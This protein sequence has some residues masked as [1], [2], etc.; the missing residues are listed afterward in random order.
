MTTPGTGGLPT[1]RP[2]QTRTYPSVG[3]QA[4]S[5][6]GIFRGRLVIISGSSTNGSNG[7]FV[8]SGTPGPGNLILSISAVAGTDQ[9]GNQFP[10]GLNVTQ[11]VISGTTISAA[12]IIAGALSAGSIGG[13]AI[14][15]S[16]FTGGSVTETQVLFD[17]TGGALLVYTTTTVTQTFTTSGSF[18][19]PAGVTQLNVQATGG[20][21]GGSAGI[22]NQQSGFGGQGA[23]Y[24][25]EPALAVTAGNT[26]PYTVGLGG[27]ATPAGVFTYVAGGN[28]V[29]AGD[30]AT[31]TAHGGI[32]A[33]GSGPV[34][35]NTI[36][37]PG[38]T[39]GNAGG[40]PGA[41]GGGGGGGSG[42]ATSAG[43]NG[44]NHVNN[45]GGAGGV[46]RAGGGGGGNGGSSAAAG[47][48][49]TAPGGGGGGG[50][51]TVTTQFASGAGAN[52]QVVVS[53]VTAANRALLLSIAA[54]A[55]SDAFGNA[56]GP[57]LVLY[58]GAQPA[59]LAGAAE[60]YA[61]GGQLKYVSADTNAYATGRLTMVCPGQTIPAAT[62][63]PIT[64]LSC[65]VGIGTY[66]F[67]AHIVF[68]GN[69]A[70][71]IGNN[72]TAPTT[73][74]AVV[75]YLWFNAGGAAAFSQATSTALGTG[76]LGPTMTAADQV[77]KVEGLATFTAA[78][79]FTLNADTSIAADNL[80]I[81]A[82]ST[83]E[84]FPVP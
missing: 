40:V 68:N 17:S 32:L 61:A 36:H 4:G 50:G 24:A 69:V 58:N 53:Y 46:A 14:T 71:R 54:V 1:P 57:G 28:T 26:Y 79:T 2:D 12:S 51:A 80:V 20:G 35:S 48:N 18:L 77:L 70:A 81:I 60:L 49:G 29:F 30:S 34:S 82:G 38:G 7:L 74:T 13:S 76:V 22:A 31:V 84:V 42:V 75:S 11:G 59:A 10:A 78:G 65:P 16:T 27:T 6:S 45:L 19:V 5:S 37:F 44:G 55:G 9:Y 83:L 39:G 33:A 43:N 21:S 66:K 3:S 67:Q 23:E 41:A 64:N 62:A 15:G 63:T 47:A 25:A 8:Y 56:Y 52:G 72:I 73:S